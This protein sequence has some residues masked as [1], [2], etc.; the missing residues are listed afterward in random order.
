MAEKNYIASSIKEFTTQ[1]G[2][3]INANLKL[4]ELQK[5]AKNGWVQI[6]I[7]ERKTPSEK[8]A[9]HYAFENTYEA[10]KKDTGKSE[11]VTSDDTDVPF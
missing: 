5:I 7:A 6:T 8:G 11:F 10:P 4:D 1:Y 9:T 2:T 3:L